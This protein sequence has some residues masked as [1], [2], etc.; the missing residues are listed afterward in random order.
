M[1]DGPGAAVGG[2]GT[3]PTQFGPGRDAG[4][5]GP[6]AML[7]GRTAG[8]GGGPF[9]HGVAP[10]QPAPMTWSPK[11][12]GVAVAGFLCSVL[13]WPIGL[14]LSIA[15]MRRTRGPMTR[16]HGLAVAGLVLSM[17]GAVLS[18]LAAF[19]LGPVY[20][21]QHRVAQEA[22]VSTAL[23]QTGTWV[24]DMQTRNGG[25]PLALDSTAPRTDPV[26]VRLVPDPNGGAPC[27]DASLGG[28][29]M[30]TTPR[31]GH[32]PIVGVCS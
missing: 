1:P 17:L 26:R 11:V 28:T 30:T 24:Q 32:G 16:G 13:L 7:R 25:Y 21:S 20:L 9:G 6:T 31:S 8:P 2:I 10:I 18:G 3:V 27:L 14:V 15:G 12:D 22:Q 29:T 5:A 23:D 4:S 19:A